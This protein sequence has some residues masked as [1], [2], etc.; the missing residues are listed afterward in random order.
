MTYPDVL[1]I[2]PQRPPF[3]VID[4]LLKVDDEITVT[5]YTVP[6][7]GVFTSPDGYMHEAGVVENIA[8]TCAARIGYLNL[9]NGVH[10]G[11]IG[12]VRKLSFNMQPKVGDL[13]TT[14]IRIESEAFGITLA[15][16]K[17]ENASGEIV[18]E[19]EMKVMVD[20]K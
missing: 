20:K 16:A 11:V 1:V 4:H 17:V 2:L 19:G 3:I 8:Q 18:A 10:V 7:E 13:L 5:D 15:S 12:A 6:A 14:T 9:H